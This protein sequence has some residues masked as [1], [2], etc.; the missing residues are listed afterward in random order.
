IASLLFPLL[1][2]P[3]LGLIRT[4]FLFGIINV[5][6]AWVLLLRPVPIRGVGALRFSAGA[7]MVILVVGFA[8]SSEL[9]TLAEEGQF[10]GQA[11]ISKS[12]AYQ[13]IVVTR[14]ADDIRLFL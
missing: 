4:S 1:L 8:Y 3:Q 14:Q 13:R 7:A 11:I 9:T 10:P 6:V 2:V 5:G 12:T